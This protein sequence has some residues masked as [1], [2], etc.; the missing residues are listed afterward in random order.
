MYFCR[1]RFV[2]SIQEVENA[3]RAMNQAAFQEL[4]DLFMI[5]KNQNYSAFVCTG[6]QYGKQKTTKGTPDTFI[7][8]QDGKYILVEYSTNE[9]KKEKKLIDDFEKC[10]KEKGIE[11]SK[12]N[13][14]IL[15]A[16]YKLN[17]EEAIAIHKYAEKTHTPCQ[18]YDGCALAREL[19]INH[20]DLIFECLGIPVD[21]GQI[22]TVDSFV[23]EYDNAAGAIAAPLS[24]V[25][26]YREQEVR[27]IK[28]A[29]EEKDFILLHGA[30]GVGKTKL[31]I[32]AISEYR[33]DNPEFHVHCISY[34][35]GEL[36]TDLICNINL[37]EDNIIFVDDINRVSSFNSIVGFYSSKRKEKLK[38]VMTVRDYALEQA[39][40]MCFPHDRLELQVNS[41]S[42]EQISEIV[43]LAFHIENKMYLDKICTISKGNPRIAM[44]AGKLAV[45]KQN[46]QSLNDV[47]ELF[48]AYYGNIIDSIKYE[49]K[50]TLK[51]CAGIIAFFSPL[52]FE[53]NDEL[54][55]ILD[56]FR[57][58]QPEFMECIDVLNRYEIIDLP[59]NIYAKVNEQNLCMYLF[60]LAFIKEK[61]VSLKVLFKNFYATHY[62]RVRDCIIP[63]NNT[64]GPDTIGKT[65]S[66]DLLQYYNSVRDAKTKFLLLSDFWPYLMDEAFAYI[67]DAVY[68]LPSCSKSDFSFEKDES[69]FVLNTNEDVLD[70]SSKIF[71]FAGKELRTAIELAFEY[72]R[73]KP[74][75]ASSLI[76]H[77]NEQFMYRYNDAVISHYRQSELLN[78]VTKQIEKGD[79]LCQQIMWYIAKLFLAFVTNYSG[80]AIERDRFSFYQYQVPALESILKI[81]DKIWSTIEIYYSSDRFSWLLKCYMSSSW[82]RDDK[83]PKHDIPFILEIIK[84]CM[85]PKSFE[86]CLCVQKYIEW[87]KRND[88]S[89][90]DYDFYYMKY[91]CKEYKFYV[92]LTGNGL[93]DMDR[94]TN[95]YY[96]Y[97]QSEL[98]ENFIYRTKQGYD[99]F[100]ARYTSLGN[101]I[102][103]ADSYGIKDSLNFI[104]SLAFESDSN[105]GCHLLR[106]IIQYNIQDFIPIALFAN[107]LNSA[108]KAKRILK[109]IQT[110]NFDMKSEWIVKYFEFIPVTFLTKDDLTI[111][112]DAVNGCSTGVNLVL[113]NLKKLTGLDPSI[114]DNI[115]VQIYSLNEKGKR[116]QLH[117]HDSEFIYN[118]C[119]SKE[120]IQNTY[121]QQVNLNKFFDYEL[122]GLLSLLQNNPHFL[123]DYIKSVADNK[124]EPDSYLF[125]I[126]EVERIESAVEETLKYFRLDSKYRYCRAD[127]WER[128]IFQKSNADV[129]LDKAKA[130]LENQFQK[131]LGDERY[132]EQIVLIA[133]GIFNDLYDR[134]ISDYINYIDS[135][136]D[137]FRIDW[138]NLHS[139]IGPYGENTTYGD[140]E[141]ARWSSLLSCLEGI[142]TPKVYAIKSK[143][144]SYV[145]SW[146]K[147]AESE[148]ARNQLWH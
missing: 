3:I 144:R 74:S 119:C 108:T 29:L 15:I 96:K 110:A 18:V 148:R 67:S 1:K 12:L 64:Y 8:T 55:L 24:N 99:S 115:L 34:K 69:Y 138:L 30:P 77:I 124:N 25:F 58:S 73:R 31:A 53:G 79:V 95:A 142:T 109:V 117:Y 32:Q 111:L 17:K 10:L 133:R 65:V 81:R 56:L 60:Y 19:Y 5:R 89:K 27:D 43:R 83:L 33:R 145:I 103:V 122:K 14:I 52:K 102:S 140:I 90:K 37:D 141:A 35:G 7:H 40:Q 137:F 135:P 38:I 113:S 22:V 75:S 123:V 93:R 97:R 41:M 4:G 134:F 105:L 104:V 11:K 84:K 94:D 9:T 98:K 78:Y 82:G 68:S 139:V 36:L 88:M 51:K 13:T 127:N 130:F 86:D 28:N 61:V 85:N 57:I 39:R 147:E 23:Q 80:A 2:M 72:V 128:A 16:N 143:I 70:L 114:I 91:R 132:V 107:H 62:Q 136:D 6:S 42:S 120:V 59:Q 26:L 63:V 87:A 129:C 100:L 44:M 50:K 118:T 21:T 54:E 71:A 76:R 125:R 101:K 106:R 47:S 45:K 92:L 49:D 48:D 46:L 116:I 146:Q 20:K 121:L 126:W 131:A 112:M 66:P